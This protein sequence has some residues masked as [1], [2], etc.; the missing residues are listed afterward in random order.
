MMTLKD[1]ARLSD[2]EVFQDT[3]GTAVF[4][5]QVQLF[6]ESVRSGPASLRRIIETAPEVAI[7]AKRTV[8]EVSSGQ[9]FILATGSADWYKGTRI[10][11]KYP[12]LPVVRPFDILTVAQ[13]LAGT[14]GT[15]G[16]YALP[17][18]I[19]R[20]VLEESSGYLGGYEIVYSPYYNFLPA[21][22]VFRGGG[23][24]FK[25][26]ETS[27]EDDIGLGVAE[28]V[29]LDGPLQTTTYKD[30]TSKY[31]PGTDSYVGVT[32]A[33]VQVFVEPL[34]LNFKHEI[35][36]YVKPQPGDLAITV[37][38]TAA[39]ALTAGDT[40]DGFQVLSV[41]SVDGTWCAHARGLRT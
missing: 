6:N 30:N 5:G 2:D 22:T 1:L 16:I 29:E 20:V 26:R 33:S 11:V 13:V 4:N 34:A 21:G 41:T 12:A 39:P 9:K 24:W 8:T 17:S 38:K 18:Y 14:G 25:T 31:D 15:L 35:L 27:R 28:V 37:L 19:R 32:P 40:F 36:G 23:Q 3:Y 7:P 10:A